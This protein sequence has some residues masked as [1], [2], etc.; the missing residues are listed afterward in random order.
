[1]LNLK[2]EYVSSKLEAGKLIIKVAGY[3]MFDGGPSR[4]D[5]R[6]TETS[7][8]K[9]DGTKHSTLLGFNTM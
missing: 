3:R 2:K 6:V 5:I 9:S 4:Y 8:T 7:C 1:M